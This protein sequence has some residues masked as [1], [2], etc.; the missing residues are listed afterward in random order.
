MSSRRQVHK[1]K[2]Q[3]F[4]SSPFHLQIIS[5]TS[6]IKM[7]PRQG[8]VAL[9]PIDEDREMAYEDNGDACRTLSK[10]GLCVALLSLLVV[11]VSRFGANNPLVNIIGNSQLR[12]PP[13]PALAGPHRVPGWEP[14]HGDALFPPHHPHAEKTVKHHQGGEI[15]KHYNGPPGPLHDFHHNQ[16]D[17]P[18]YTL[19]GRIHPPVAPMKAFHWPGFEAAWHKKN[20]IRHKVPEARHHDAPSPRSERK[21]PPSDFSDSI[22]DMPQDA[23]D[24]VKAEIKETL[25]EELEDVVVEEEQVEVP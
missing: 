3:I 16:K 17:G 18:E 13:K 8:Y 15:I 7:T 21:R 9:H 6:T 20:V 19:D 23:V 22:E 4:Q 1:I 11:G 5:Q 2:P 24:M 12:A 14:H 10:I 25:A